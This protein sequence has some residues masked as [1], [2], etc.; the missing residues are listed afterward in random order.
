[1]VV[2][3]WFFVVPKAAK[4]K[5]SLIFKPVFWLK[6]KVFGGA[7]DGSRTHYLIL[8]NQTRR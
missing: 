3:W 6:H 7:D 5:K 8:T 4:Q 1:M 2:F